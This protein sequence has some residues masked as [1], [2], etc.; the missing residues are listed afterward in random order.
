VRA[1]VVI[2]QK[3]LLKVCEIEFSLNQMLFFS[4]FFLLCT[5]E[6]IL[7]KLCVLAI[8]TP[9]KFKRDKK[10]IF[11]IASSSQEDFSRFSETSQGV[12][13]D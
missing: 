10:F 8:A 6:Y 13:S 7:A 12:N 5:V 3:S 9:L 11:H 1:G 4:F 2:S